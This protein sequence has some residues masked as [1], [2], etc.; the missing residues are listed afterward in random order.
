[1]S[2]TSLTIHQI[3]AAEREQRQLQRAEQRQQV[4]AQAL[5]SEARQSPHHVDLTQPSTTL[6]PGPEPPRRPASRQ[7]VVA[8]SSAAGAQREARERGREII[9]LTAEEGEEENEAGGGREV[10][11]TPATQVSVS[12]LNASSCLACFLSTLLPGRRKRNT[13]DELTCTYQYSLAKTSTQT[14]GLIIPSCTLT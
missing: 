5:S 10:S 12:R 2:F 11:M 14:L 1:M 13:S 3:E 4:R 6:T 9:D 7:Q 8:E